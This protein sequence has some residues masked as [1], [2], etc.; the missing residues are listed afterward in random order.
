M[1]HLNFSYQ[2]PKGS[3]VKGFNVDDVSTVMAYCTPNEEDGYA[4]SYR[5]TGKSFVLLPFNG[6]DGDKL[7]CRTVNSVETVEAAARCRIELDLLHHEFGTLERRYDR[8]IFIHIYKPACISDRTDVKVLVQC[9]WYGPGIY[10]VQTWL[11]REDGY[12][13]CLI[14]ARFMRGGGV[15]LDELH[16]RVQKMADALLP[17]GFEEMVDTMILRDEE[18]WQRE[19]LQ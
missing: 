4:V 3:A 1:K 8:P 15:P 14:G 17:Q 7:P 12:D 9:Y 18:E 19:A 16:D 2:L 6:F 10:Q 13:I 11:I 5:L